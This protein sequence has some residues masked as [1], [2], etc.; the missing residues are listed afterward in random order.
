MLLTCGVVYR[1]HVDVVTAAPL[2]HYP[3]DARQPTLRH[4]GVVAIVTITVR[5]WQA[6]HLQDISTITKK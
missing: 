3:C 6:L 1:R 4:R 5:V 2:N